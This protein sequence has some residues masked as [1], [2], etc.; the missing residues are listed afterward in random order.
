M[1]S[2][3]RLAA[4]DIASSDAFSVEAIEQELITAIVSFL[5]LNKE[6]GS[7]LRAS[8]FTLENAQ[9][10]FESLYETDND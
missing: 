7:V 2:S 10:W 3:V 9:Q 6:P 4:L 8:E 1:T 5:T